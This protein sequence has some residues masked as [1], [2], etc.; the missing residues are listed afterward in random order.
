MLQYHLKNSEIN[1]EVCKLFIEIAAAVDNNNWIATTTT[2]KTIEYHHF[3]NNIK[4][5]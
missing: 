3:V 5:I 2:I 4:Q 1:E